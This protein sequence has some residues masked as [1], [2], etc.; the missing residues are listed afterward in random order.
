MKLPKKIKILG[1]PYTVKYV[2]S[3]L[4]IG[5]EDEYLWGQTVYA[6]ET[7]T[8]YVNSRSKKSVWKTLLHE[9]LHVLFIEFE[10][11][12]N[13][14]KREAIVTQLATGLSAIIIDNKFMEY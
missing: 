6:T 4:K 3:Q 5:D 13:D 11:E 1:I 10:I 12:N 14:K 8:I 7:I 9:V 2:N